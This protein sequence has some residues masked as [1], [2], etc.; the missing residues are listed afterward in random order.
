MKYIKYII[1]Y[2]AFL[3]GY[4]NLQG[5]VLTGKIKDTAGNFISNANVLIKS[6]SDSTF[7]EGTVSDKNGSFIFTSEQPIP[8]LLQIS[9]IGYITVINKIDSLPI[10]DIILKP[11]QQKL[12]EVII[13]GQ[14]R[15]ILNN[16]HGVLTL[17]VA[18]SYLKDD[19]NMFS[20]LSKIPGV[21]INGETVG[22]FGKKNVNIY[23]DNRK[24][25][26]ES[27]VSMLKPIEITHI[28]II[29]S[30]GAEYDAN[31]DGIIK[32][33]TNRRNFTNTTTVILSNET[34]INHGLANKPSLAINH[35]KGKVSHAF[36]YNYVYSDGSKQHDLNEIKNYLPSYVNT[37]IKDIYLHPKNNNHSFFY[38]LSLKPIT[39]ITIGFQY[40]GFVKNREIKQ[41]GQQ[42]IL[43]DNKQAY[44]QNIY[45]LNQEKKQLHNFGFNLNYDIN[46]KL[47]FTFI[48][49]YA[50]A[51]FKTTNYV[52]ESKSSADL[53]RNINFSK[54]NYDI[55]SFNPQIKYFGNK[56]TLV[57]GGKLALMKDKADV[58]YEKNKN[59]NTNKLTE[60]LAALYLQ[61]SIKTKIVN[62]QMGIRGEISQTE[63]FKNASKE[64]KKVYRDLFP[65][66]LLSKTIRNNW[67]ITL[68]YR[69]SINRPS[70]YKLDPTYTYKDTLSYNI[71]NPQLKP[72]TSN[73]FDLTISYKSLLFEA[74]YYINKNTC[75]LLDLPD[76]KNPDVVKSTY[77]NLGRTNYVF[78]TGLSY[79]YD[80]NY[81]S[82]IGSFMIDFPH[83]EIP[84]M[85]EFIAKDKPLWYLQLSTN[86][87]L[88]KTL[89]LNIAYEYTSSGD[90]NTMR[91]KSYSSLDLGL[92]L[93][94]LNKSLLVSAKV[95]DILHKNFSNSW[96]SDRNNIMYKIHSIPD[97]RIF[98]I[99]L[100]YL[101]GGKAKS[102]RKSSSNT[103]F[104]NRL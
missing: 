15:R 83:I 36:N 35:S 1:F 34:Q 3:I 28:E 11:Y 85:N 74:G 7:I 23:I 22:I 13:V 101:L 24:I 80:K 51:Y 67:D 46:K 95:Y 103:E 56:A 86:T 54:S 18:H 26:S 19:A 84:Y 99:N 57:L 92:N 31:C 71:G 65:Y 91:S 50:Y 96:Y 48:G 55:I 81:F 82:F 89:S 98:A 39:K 61:T 63:I 62:L 64:T 90:Y 102:I 49:D 94:L 4:S 42:Y 47:N 6:I 87:N 73:L 93:F 100:R 29:H 41:S 79:S 75:Y 97:S 52:E 104:R 30:P 88:L 43:Q 21:K 45:G 14:K 40:M 5:Q 2:F 58:E 72:E 76:D 12:D 27:E 59:R 78:H 37:S 77:G 60:E 38:G 33:Y 8:F 53:K 25:V 17:N 10:C 70:I 44:Q 9:C 68:S 69:K 20:L 16:K 32:I 66:L